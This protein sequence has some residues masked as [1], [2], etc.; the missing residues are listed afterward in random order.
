MRKAQPTG[1]GKLRGVEFK[2]CVQHH[3]AALST[4][5]AQRHYGK[6]SRLLTQQLTNVNGVVVR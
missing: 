1:A 5:P 2:T 4:E 6:L 3:V